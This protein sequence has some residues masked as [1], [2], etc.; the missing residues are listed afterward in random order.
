[1]YGSVHFY[2]IFII[3]DNISI[4]LFK[5][6]FF[7]SA[8]ILI[9]YE[10]K[11]VLKYTSLNFPKHKYLIVNVSQNIKAIIERLFNIIMKG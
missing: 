7:K 6:C 5:K 10:I 9:K 8:F 11:G 2:L 4:F 1:M 3:T